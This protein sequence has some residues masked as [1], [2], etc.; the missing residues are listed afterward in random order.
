[1]MAE[2]FD[3]LKSLIYLPNNSREDIVCFLPKT[4]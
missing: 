2:D 3:P 1:M 4:C